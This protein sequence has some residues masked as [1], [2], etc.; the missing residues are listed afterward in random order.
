MAYF[1]IVENASLA[2]TYPDV[3][4]AYMMYMTVPVCSVLKNCPHYVY[5]QSPKKSF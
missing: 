1:L 4:T 3:C 2:N 5:S